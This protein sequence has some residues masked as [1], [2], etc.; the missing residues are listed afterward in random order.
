MYRLAHLPNYMVGYRLV[1]RL[2]YRPGPQSAGG[3]GWGGEV[4]VRLAAGRRAI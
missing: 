1:Y 3:V 2:A 4:S